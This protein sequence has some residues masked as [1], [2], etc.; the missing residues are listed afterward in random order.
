MWQ[1]SPLG[2]MA[3]AC[4][5]LVAFGVDRLV[6]GDQTVWR[7]RVSRAGRAAFLVARE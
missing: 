6:C 5:S 3:F 2:R 7:Q 1:A 4:V